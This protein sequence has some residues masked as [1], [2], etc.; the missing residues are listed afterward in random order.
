MHQKSTSAGAPPQLP[1]PPSWNK[2][3]P[4]LSEGEKYK[5][6]KGR[7]GCRKGRGEDERGGKGSAEDPPYV[8]LNFSQNRPSLCDYRTVITSLN[9]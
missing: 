3:D 8:S 5:N 2:G 6:E 9:V 4:L 7:T 1:R